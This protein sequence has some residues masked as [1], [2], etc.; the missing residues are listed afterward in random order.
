MDVL[1]LPVVQEFLRCATQL[2]EH[3]WAERNGG[4]GG[5]EIP[6]LSG[7]RKGRLLI[8]AGTELPLQ[9]LQDFLDRWLSRN[10][11]ELDYI[12]GE[13]ALAAMSGEP[14]S[15]GFRLMSGGGHGCVLRGRG[16]A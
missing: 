13:E 8:P 12:H 1:S 10:A 4:K 6:W 2:Y 11:G 16:S 14:G 15:V 5:T 7:G 3:G 9:P